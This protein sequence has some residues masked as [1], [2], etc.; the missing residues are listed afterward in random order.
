[1]R[2]FVKT[3]NG[4]FKR[5]V[6]VPHSM[7]WQMLANFMMMVEI[8]RCLEEH[9]PNDGV[10]T[11]PRPSHCTW[12]AQTRSKWSR[13]RS[14]TRKAFLQPA[15]AWFFRASCLRTTTHLQTT[16][17][18]KIGPCT[19]WFD[20]EDRDSS[21]A[22]FELRDL[23]PWWIIDDDWRPDPLARANSSRSFAGSYN[24]KMKCCKWKEFRQLWEKKDRLCNS[25]VKKRKK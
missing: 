9:W 19:C 11:Q 5:T 8:I 2:I 20:R 10:F 24:A 1:M 6:T 3:L 22:W 23:E 21:W 7:L 13:A 4:T 17:S 16:V 14:R 15:S 12:M 18:A 25:I